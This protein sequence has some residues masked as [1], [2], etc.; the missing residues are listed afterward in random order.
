MLSLPSALSLYMSLSSSHASQQLESPQLC[1]A[2]WLSSSSPWTLATLRPLFGPSMPFLPVRNLHS[3]SRTCVPSFCAQCPRQFR[4]PPGPHFSML[5][6]FCSL[7]VPHPDRTSFARPRVLALPAI[8]VYARMSECSVP[9]R[10][11]MVFGNHAPKKHTTRRH[12]APA[13]PSPPLDA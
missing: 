2:S 5:F 9:R 7:P 3:L 6:D 4:D 13:R 12:R 10:V 1:H 8:S 11:Q